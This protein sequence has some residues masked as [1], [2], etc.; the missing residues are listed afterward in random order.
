MLRLAQK[1]ARHPTKPGF[2]VLLTDLIKVYFEPLVGIRLLARQREVEEKYGESQRT[3]DAGGS[4]LDIGGEEAVQEVLDGLDDLMRDMLGEAE[5]AVSSGDL[6]VSSAW[7]DTL[8]QEPS[9]QL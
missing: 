4:S 9:A 6:Y 5:M 7:R 3:K 1:Y 8:V 2:I